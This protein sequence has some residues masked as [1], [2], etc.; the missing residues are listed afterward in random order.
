[1]SVLVAGIGNIFLGDDG[2]GPE[3]IRRLQAEGSPPKGVRIVD[4]G[5]RGMF[6]AFD[7]LG[8]DR[9]IL[10]DALPTADPEGSSGEGAPGEIVMLEIGP[11]DIEPAGFDAHAMSPGIVLGAVHQL[12]ETLPPTYLVGCRVDT[13]FEDIGLTPRVEAAIPRAMEAVHTLV[14]RCLAELPP[15]PDGPDP[16]WSPVARIFRE[17]PPEPKGPIFPSG[18]P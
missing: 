8:V 11:D 15:P 6:L 1:V 16:R 18:R 13:A 10:V 7:L 17:T 12:G 14:D 5:I 2:F 9:L 3:V 4:Y